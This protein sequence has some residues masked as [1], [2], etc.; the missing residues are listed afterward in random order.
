MIG[1]QHAQQQRPRQ[2]A[3]RIG[4]AIQRHQP[5]APLLHHQLVDPAFAKNEHD[6]Q[7]HPDHQPQHQPHRVARQDRQQADGHRP[8]PQAQA[9]QTRSAQPGRQ[10]TGNLRPQQHAEGRHRSHHSNGEAAVAPAFQA[11]GHQRHADTQRQTNAEH[12]GQHGEI[13]RP[14]HFHAPV[15]SFFRAANE[16]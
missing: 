2:L 11:Q 6:G 13:S 14:T 5:A 8:R 7:D 16:L 10:P 3:Q 9:H 15:D 4:A 1:A 12:R